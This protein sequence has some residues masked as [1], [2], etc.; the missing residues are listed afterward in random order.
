MYVEVN[1]RLLQPYGH[2][3]I[4]KNDHEKTD[5]LVHIY[6]QLN[7]IPIYLVDNEHFFI[8]K[9]LILLQAIEHIT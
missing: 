3:S 2:N 6:V 5:T 9:L 7:I 8:I 4:F 1:K